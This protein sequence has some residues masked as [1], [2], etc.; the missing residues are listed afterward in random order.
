LDAFREFDS[1]GKGFISRLDLELA[2]NDI[3]IFPS[4]DELYLIFKRADTDN[5]GLVR[6]AEFIKVISP[7]SSEYAALLNKRSPH[8]DTPDAG[9]HNF[10]FETKLIF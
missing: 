4:R 1:T 9:I 6:Y 3:G 10:G 5:D 8:Y 7:Q 2:L